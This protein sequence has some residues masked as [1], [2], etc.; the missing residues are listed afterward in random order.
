MGDSSDALL[1]LRSRPIDRV[2]G[3]HDLCLDGDSI[4]WILNH[5]DYFVNQS[6]GN[7]STNELESWAAA[8]CRCIAA[9]LKENASL[10]T[11]SIR[12]RIIKIKA[13]DYVKMIIVL[14]YNTKLKSI[15]FRYD[16]RLL[17]L[18]NDEDKKK[19]KILKKKYGIER[20]P[21]IELENWAGHP[22]SVRSQPRESEWLRSPLEEQEAVEVDPHKEAPSIPPPPPPPD[23]FVKIR[24]Y[25]LNLGSEFIGLSYRQRQQLCLGPFEEPPP[26]LTYSSSEGS[27]QVPDSNSQAIQTAQIFRGITVSTDGTILMQNE[28][29]TS[30]DCESKTKRG[31]KSRQAAGI[32]KAVDLVGEAMVPGSDK[33]TN[34]VSIFVVGE[35]DDIRQLVRDGS[36]RLR[37]AEG[38]PDEAL[39]AVN[40][41]RA[42]KKETMHLMG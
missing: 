37:E 26:Y 20:L 22:A 29:A 28:E 18:S 33:A 32:D 8:L 27:I 42:Q 41:P 3:W 24:A 40:R 10:E 16:G 15:L 13:K 6:R 14:Q 30:S 12:S 17:R 23:N 7:R 11:I 19:A 38:L 31:E 4:P 35:Y 21:D 2:L 9:M 36:K 1:Q 34:L 39:L 5:I 25:K